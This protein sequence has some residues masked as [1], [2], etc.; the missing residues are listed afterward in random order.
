MAYEGTPTEVSKNFLTH[1]IESL[2][3]LLL[4]Q[5]KNEEKDFQESLYCFG[6]ALDQKSGDKRIEFQIYTGRAKLNMLRAQYGHTKDDMLE[7]IKRN[8]SDEQAWYILARCRLLVNQYAECLKYIDLGLK[9]L[10]ENKKL[11]DLK[12]QCEA[13]QEKELKRA[14][15]ISSI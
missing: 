2:S 12:K 3:K 8:D 1:A 5:S 11:L 4:K 9:K 15:A 7:A 10:P 14:K 6:E 13:A